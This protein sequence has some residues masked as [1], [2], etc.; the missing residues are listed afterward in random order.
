MELL[1]RQDNRKRHAR[2]R[3]CL[4]VVGGAALVIVAGA[5]AYRWYDRLA[6][7]AAFAYRFVIENPYFSVREIQIRGGE[8]V[9]GDEIIA[10]AGLRHGANI[11]RIDAVAIE[12]KLRKHPWVRRVLVRREFPRKVVVEV[13][14]R[15]PKAIVA[16]GRLYYVDADAVLFKEVGHG[17]KVKFPMLT[18]LRSDELTKPEPK[19]R[20]RIQEALALAELLPDQTL[21]EIRFEGSDRLVLY[22]SAYRVALHMGSGDWPG[23]LK[24]FERV[25]AL[26]KG[27]EDRLAVLNLA[28]RDQV[29]ARPRAVRQ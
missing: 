5:A 17:D 6:G 20:A 19:T 13:E 1:P 26:W 22:S 9:K 12:A 16:V 8:N 29:V 14:E 27:S 4:A 28:F 21:S 15:K 25:M 3:R 10:A 24:R 18:G 7:P 11:W 23:K 2:A